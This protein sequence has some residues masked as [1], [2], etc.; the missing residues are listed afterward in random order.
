MSPLWIQQS[1]AFSSK[2]HLKTKK[3]KSVARVT[4][5]LSCTHATLAEGLKWTSKPS[6]RD[7]CSENTTVKAGS[8]YRSQ[9]SIIT[10]LSLLLKLLRGYYG[11]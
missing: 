8:I 5:T 1:P 7:T 2:K 4:C 10:R 9:A 11:N 3:E 6:P